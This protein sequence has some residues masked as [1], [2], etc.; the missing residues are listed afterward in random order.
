MTV[1]SLDGSIELE[2]AGCTLRL[3]DIYEG[4]QFPAEAAAAE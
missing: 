1:T 4:V 3:R 2:S